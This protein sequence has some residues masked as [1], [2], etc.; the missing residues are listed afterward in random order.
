MGYDPVGLRGNMGR[1]EPLG[2]AGASAAGAGEP[3]PCILRRTDIPDALTDRWSL[4]RTGN[5]SGRPLE[6]EPVGANVYSHQAT[7]GDI[8]PALP[9]FNPI[10]GDA[11]LRLATGWS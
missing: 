3:R 8:Q 1:Q 7:S 2:R 10:S 6:W 9:Q 11:M 5:G 4:R